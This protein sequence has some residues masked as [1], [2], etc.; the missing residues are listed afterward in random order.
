MGGVV[1]SFSQQ[2]TVITALQLSKCRSPTAE[3]PS[4]FFVNLPVFAK[5]CY[6]N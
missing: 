3:I 4:K 1:A 2:K 6:I 5:R